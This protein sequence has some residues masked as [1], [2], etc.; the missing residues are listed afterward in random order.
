MNCKATLCE[1]LELQRSLQNTHWISI[2]QILIQTQITKASP[3][4]KAPQIAC[5]FDLKTHVLSLCVFDLLNPDTEM[6]ISSE[7]STYSCE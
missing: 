5:R 3:L 1:C 6:L 2:L 4:L 7:Y